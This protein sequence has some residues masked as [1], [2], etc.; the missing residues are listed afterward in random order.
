MKSPPTSSEKKPA[1]EGLR[2][3]ECEYN[4]TGLDRDVCPECGE[5]FD[6]KRLLAVAPSPVPI[7]GWRRE[8]GSPKAFVLTLLEIWVHPIRFGRRFPRTPILRDARVFSRWCLGISILIAMVAFL[9][10]NVAS[11][12][13][14]LDTLS[15]IIGVCTGVLF[16]EFLIAGTVFLPF[17]GNIEEHLAFQNSLALVRMTRAFLLLS[18]LCISIGVSGEMYFRSDWST[19]LIAVFGTCAV[20]G[21]WWLCMVL[22]AKAHCRDGISIVAA[23]LM[24]PV[25]T[26]IS[27]VAGTFT[28]FAILGS[29][30]GLPY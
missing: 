27:C 10:R 4:L 24:I 19:Q 28:A 2:C 18:T 11:L 3:P 5:G 23:A 14:V 13:D 16:C 17:T 30:G 12:N 6:R 29:F 21:Y 8:I 22:I 9:P 25:L 15:T 20:V 7:W 1:D 26:A